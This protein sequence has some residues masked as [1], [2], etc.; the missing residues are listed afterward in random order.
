MVRVFC[1]ITDL[2]A[3]WAARRLASRGIEIDIVTAPVL[4]SALKWD[5]RLTREGD[6]RSCL[7]LGDGRV[8]SSDNPF[9]VLNRL[10]WVPTDRLDRVAGADR[11]YAVQEMNALLLS[12]MHALP[13]PVI[14]RPTPQGL[15]GNWRDRSV[16]SSLAFQA[17][18]P[19]ASYRQSCTDGPTEMWPPGRSQLVVTVFVVGNR[20]VAPPIVPAEVR[21]GCLRLMRMTRETLLGIDFA[22]TV[23]KR[24]EWVGASPLPDLTRGTEPL[25]DA[26]AEALQP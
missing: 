1:E 8:L 14:N 20:V 9:A 4:G 18:L 5:H 12:W 24:L 2:A 19:A 15:G 3:L 11:D 10:S 22:P 16:W 21:E 6:V 23:D 25:I 26:L 17:G 7:E 13:G